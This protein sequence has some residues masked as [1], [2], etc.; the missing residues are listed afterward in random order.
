MNIR[1]LARTLLAIAVIGGG[2]SNV[3]FSQAAAPTDA[4][5]QTIELKAQDLKDRLALTPDQEQKL[6]PLLEARN[7]KLK[8]VFANY[9]PDASRR[10]KR[11]MMNEAKEIQ[12]NFTQQI[13]PILTPEQMSEWEAFRK[14]NRQEMIDRYRNRQK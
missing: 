12:E 6:Q 14:E 1:T 4:Q 3:A 11:A 9:N 7:A 10:D 5:R 2:A 8:G 13:K